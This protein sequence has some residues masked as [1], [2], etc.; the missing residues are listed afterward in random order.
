MAETNMQA[1]IWS[2]YRFIA[3][4]WV[5]LN[6]EKID[7]SRVLVSFVTVALADE[8]VSNLFDIELIEQRFVIKYSRE[9]RYYIAKREL[10]CVK[11]Y[12]STI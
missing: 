10:I 12:F 5:S 7:N 11:N 6:T 8:L 2:R 1:Y 4:P 9:C 3:P